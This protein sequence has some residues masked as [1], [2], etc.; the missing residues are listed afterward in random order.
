VLPVLFGLHV[1][2]YLQERTEWSLVYIFVYLYRKSF[3]LVDS[4]QLFIYCTCQAFCSPAVNVSSLFSCVLAL[5]YSM[6]A[7]GIGDIVSS[8]AFLAC[9]IMDYKMTLDCVLPVNN[10]SENSC[11]QLDRLGE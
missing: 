3:A 10:I 11:L 4:L 6:E 7:V 8:T 2:L 1:Q 9:N 5:L